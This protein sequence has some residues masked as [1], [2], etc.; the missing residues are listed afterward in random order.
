MTDVLIRP[1]NASIESISVADVAPHNVESISC[2]D[3]CRKDNC[4][5]DIDGTRLHW[6]SGAVAG[7]PSI[8]LQIGQLDSASGRQPAEIWIA[9][10]EWEMGLAD[11]VAVAELFRSRVMTAAG[12][13]GVEMPVELARLG[14]EILTPDGWQ[15]I[16]T[17]L[18]DEPANHVGVYTPEREN[19]IEERWNF[20]PGDRVKVRMAA[21]S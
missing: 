3:W 11:A 21:V 20:E 8:E 16:E 15:R 1:E 12:A 7:N 6:S 10:T 17:L 13:D 4:A 14:E 5:P 18:I 2:P 19:E 9:D